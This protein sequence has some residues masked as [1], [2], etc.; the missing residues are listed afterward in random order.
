MTLRARL[1]LFIAVT[2]ALALLAQG[3]FGY[4]SFRRL[5]LYNL[6]RDLGSYVGRLLAD[7]RLGSEGDDRLRRGG[8][9]GRGPEGYVARARLVQDGEVL[10]AW[11]EFPSTVPLLEPAP[12]PPGSDRPMEIRSYSGWRVASLR[13]GPGTYLQAALQSQQVENSLANYRSTVLFTVLLISLLGAGVAF[14]L[15]GP[16][17]RPLQHLLE[18][19]A[20]VAHSADLSL[21]V[22]EVGGGELRQ[23]SQ[24]F[25]QMMDRL[26]AFLRRE[27][28]FTRNAAH[29]LRT[30]LAAMRLQLDSYASGQA[31]SEETL[32]VV[33]EEVERMTRL[34]EALLVLAREGRSQR[35]ACD[36]AALARAMAG[37]AGAVYEG[38]VRLELSADPL[39][40]R[41]ALSNL[42]SNARKYAPGAEVRVG[43]EL[44]EPPYKASDHPKRAFALLSVTDTGPG[45]S[46]EALERAP[47][48][49]FRAPGNRV[50]GNG[51]GLSV[52]AQVAQA[53]GG[54]LRLEPNSPHGL[55][56]EV[57][58]AVE[59]DSGG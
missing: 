13:L 32:A 3:V 50:A 15:S 6:D 1:A 7:L 19:T 35:I 56:A 4:L 28:E 5:L 20:R 37:E 40:L 58:L 26:S 49:F 38:P 30:P 14:G 59:G 47:E 33:E 39:L 21:R 46:P 29:E 18:T 48:P 11:G 36:L 25:N 9:A 16:A 31:T 2:I 42:L 10:R 22:P 51:L 41:Q 45:M 27:T 52:V 34:S 55:R 57:W 44:R 53:H 43:L 17:L 12:P 54:F 8:R 23:L 24:T